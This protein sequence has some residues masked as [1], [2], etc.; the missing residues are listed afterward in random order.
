MIADRSGWTL[1]GAVAGLVLIGA[2]VVSFWSRQAALG[3][4]AGG[5]WNAASLWSLRRMLGAWLGP[6]PSRRR[7]L[8]W[9]FVKFPCLYLLAFALLR[10]PMISAMGFGIG[11]TIVLILGLVW[12]AQQAMWLSAQLKMKMHTARVHVR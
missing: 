6:R 3:I 2:G 1:W 10:L 12:G 11:F 5:G 9:L 8:G 4:L 7:A